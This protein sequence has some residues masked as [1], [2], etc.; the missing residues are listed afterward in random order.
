LDFQISS[1]NDYLI[2]SLVEGYLEDLSVNFKGKKLYV[3]K[4]ELMPTPKFDNKLNIK[5]LS[6]IIVRTKKEVE[7]KLKSWDL[8]PGDPLFYNNLEKNL[9]KKYNEFNSEEMK[10]DNIKIISEMKFVKRKRIA[11]EKKDIK[12]FHR[13][14]M[15]DLK[16]EGATSLIKFAYDCG[17][18]EKNSMGFGMIEI[19]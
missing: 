13:A 1:P 3:E 5:T 12:T 14:F 18:G 2:K 16:V 6:P 19:L 11:I 10:D 4:V 8:S 9:I 7:G 15:M 17:L